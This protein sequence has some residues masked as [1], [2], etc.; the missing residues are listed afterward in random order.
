MTL[1]AVRG[2][3]ADDSRPPRPLRPIR[4]RAPP[5]AL[6]CA[7]STRHRK[8]G[9]DAPARPRRSHRRA[10]HRCASA[11]AWSLRCRCARFRKVRSGRALDVAHATYR[12]TKCVVNLCPRSDRARENAPPAVR[13]L[14]SRRRNGATTPMR[15][16]M[17]E[18]CRCP[19]AS[20]RVAPFRWKAGS[21]PVGCAWFPP[22]QSEE[23]RSLQ[24]GGLDEEVR[25]GAGVA[26]ASRQA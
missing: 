1:P 11:T 17:T 19:L 16:A 12:V 5:M 6:A 7:C 3:P 8:A 15:R 20:F 14:H 18:M 21:P 4:F 10:C 13:R 24:E 9:P 22:R 26:V 25:N 2:A 23:S